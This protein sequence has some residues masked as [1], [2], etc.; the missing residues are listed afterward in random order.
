MH[1]ELFTSCLAMYSMHGNHSRTWFGRIN[2]LRKL[3]SNRTIPNVKVPKAMHSTI[4]RFVRPNE[5][6]PLVA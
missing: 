5:N 1:Y 3:L 4:S 2:P 6:R